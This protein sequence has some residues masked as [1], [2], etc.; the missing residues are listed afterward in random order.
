MASYMFGLIHECKSR[1]FSGASN[2][3]GRNYGPAKEA[4]GAAGSQSQVEVSGSVPGSDA[5]QA[6]VASD[7]GNVSPMDSAVYLV[8]S[9]S[10]PWRRARSDAPCRRLD[11]AASEGNGRG[12]SAGLFDGLGGAASSG[13]GHTES[14]VECFVIS[15]SRGVGCGICWKMVMIFGRCRI[16]SGIKTS[17][18]PKSI[19]T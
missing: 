15:L 17:A 5:V 11:L 9:Q 12:G 19:L 10:G 2:L 13:C 3:C 7:G 1:V 8:S 4:F 18:P 16:C 14:G 6:I